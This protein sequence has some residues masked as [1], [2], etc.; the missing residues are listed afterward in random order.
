M[1]A[2][3]EPPTAKKVP[4]ETNV[5]I[6]QPKPINAQVMD[7]L[8]RVPHLIKTTS[9]PVGSRSHRV[10]VWTGKNGDKFD[11]IISQSF[12]VTIDEHG[13]IVKSEPE[14]Q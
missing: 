12:F 1:E 8:E 3:M 9:T 14:I 5:K 13:I 2:V 7:I 11:P 6:S 10:N 4:I